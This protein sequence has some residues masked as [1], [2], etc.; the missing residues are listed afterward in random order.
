MTRLDC[1]HRWQLWEKFLFQDSWTRGLA[2]DE[3]LPPDI[4]VKW[5]AW[6]LELHLLSD[7]HVPRW[8]GARTPDLQDCK[9]HVFGDAPERAYGAALYLRSFVDNVVIVRLIC[10]KARLAPIKRVTCCVWN[11][12]Q[13]YSPPGSYVTSVKLQITTFPRPPCG[14]IQQLPLPGSAG[15]R[16]GGKHLY[17]TASRR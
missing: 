5:L 17:A 10:S 3:T 9:V 14:V 12:W 8:I 13:R 11:Y 2:W 6:T 4:V 16:T 1:F 7:V 15:T